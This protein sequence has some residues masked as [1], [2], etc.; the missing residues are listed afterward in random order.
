[1][2]CV[3]VRYHYALMCEDGLIL[4]HMMNLKQILK[5]GTW[6]LND[7]SA[8]ER[9]DYSPVIHKH[10]L[11]N[12]FH[13][14]YSFSKQMW[15]T[16]DYQN[17]RRLMQWNQFLLSDAY[18]FCSEYR[19]TNFYQLWKNKLNTLIINNFIIKY[20]LYGMVTRRSLRWDPWRFTASLFSYVYS[21]YI[22]TL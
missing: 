18:K 15:H 7:I 5:L 19:P 8:Y 16:R 14:F 4:E 10:F 3:K 11:K 1:M 17:V 22:N 21:L 2:D 13:S 12:C 20:I 9:I 6:E